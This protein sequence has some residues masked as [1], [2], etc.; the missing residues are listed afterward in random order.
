MTK[1]TTWISAILLFVL[2]LPTMGQDN[3]LQFNRS[4]I[5][6]SNDGTLTVPV[7]KVWKVES[8]LDEN[9]PYR[10]SVSLSYPRGVTGN[11]DPCSG[12]ALPCCTCN[13][14]EQRAYSWSNCSSAG[15]PVVVNGREISIASGNDFSSSSQPSLGSP[16]WLPAG[17]TFQIA[18][19]RQCYSIEVA[20][21]PSGGSGT[22]FQEDYNDGSPS[23]RTCGTAFI[24]GN[25][26]T[27]TRTVNILEFNVVTNP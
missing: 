14:R 26:I 27:V 15:S 7:G 13:N 21:Q 1:K 25:V 10:A 17:T 18:S 8:V 19:S 2:N 22:I 5:V 24:P 6:T 23:V 3:S 20:S 16:F 4:I 12:C 9:K 11:P